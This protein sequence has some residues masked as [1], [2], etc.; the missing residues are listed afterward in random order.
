MTTDWAKLKQKRAT[1]SAIPPVAISSDSVAPSLDQESES[2]PPT[3]DVAGVSRASCISEIKAEP[4]LARSESVYLF[5]TSRFLSSRFSTLPFG[6]LDT[7]KRSRIESK[8]IF[9]A[10]YVPLDLLADFTLINVVEKVQQSF[11]PRLWSQYSTIGTYLW[12][13][14]PVI[15]NRKIRRVKKYCS[16][17]RYVTS[18]NIVQPWVHSQSIS[19]LNARISTKEVCHSPVKCK[20]G[21]YTR[22]SAKPWERWLRR[23]KEREK[24]KKLSCRIHLWELW[25]D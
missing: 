23:R 1:K 2:Q 22:W 18:F 17:A 19:S 20:I 25:G 8:R 24:G 15:D 12:D 16:N 10:W 7:R 6:P 9:C 4:L 11:R 14:A 21:S 3:R 5:E 13:V